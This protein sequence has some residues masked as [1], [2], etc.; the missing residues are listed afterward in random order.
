MKKSISSLGIA[1]ALVGI[2]GAQNTYVEA[3]RAEI[4][5]VKLNQLVYLT[6]Q[7]ASV[8]VKFFSAAQVGKAFGAVVF[9]SQTTGDVEVIGL[10]ST[11][12]P[13]VFVGSS[14]LTLS[15]QGTPANHG[16]GK[17]DLIP[18]EMFSAMVSYQLVGSSQH[19]GS[20]ALAADW[21]LMSDP[22]ASG[23]EVAV[24]V[25]AVLTPDE[26]NLPTGSRP[27][28]T[29][30]Q[31]GK[32]GPV[33][34]ASNELLFLPES[35]KEFQDFVARTGAVVLGYQGSTE[36]NPQQLPKA[37]DA[38]LRMQV[39]GD[40][41]KI[42]QLPALRRLFDS[43]EKLSVSNEA[44]LA[45]V[46]TAT[47]LWCE[48][49]AVGLNPR[50]QLH[51]QLYSPEGDWEILDDADMVIGRERIDAYGN[52]GDRNPT[53][54]NDGVY[55]IREM[56]AKISMFD[57]D[58]NPVPVGIIDSGFAPNPDFKTSHP[59]YAERNL[60]NNTSGIG[61]AQTQQEVGNSGFGEK[62]W[63]GNG[64]TTVISGVGGN[65]YGHRGIG[66]QTAV[67]K[68]YHMGLA[69]FAMGFGTA[70]DFA[71]NDGCSVIN[72]SAGYPCRVLSILGNDNICSPGDRALF[73][74]KLGLAVRGAAAAA[75][76][77]SGLLDAFLPG[78]GAAVCTSAIVA[79]ETAAAAFFATTFLGE[80]RGP[81]ETAVARATALGVPI[82]A[83]AGNDLG[84][85]D[86][87]PE[88]LASLVDLENTNLDDWQ[89]IPAVIP[90]VIAVGASSFTNNNEIP[91]FGY[92]HRANVQ[93]WGDSVD[94]W[95]PERSWY[96]APENGD[97]D[98]STVPVTSHVRRQFGGTSNSAPYVTGVIAN[99]LAIDTS[100]DRRFAPVTERPNLV[101]R[102]R[103]LLI[104][105]AYLAGSPELPDSA[106][107]VVTFMKN[108]E[109]VLVEVDEPAELLLQMARRRN[110]INPLGAVNQALANVGL[111]D[112]AALGYDMDL[113]DVDDF[114]D[115]GPPS[116]VREPVLL[117]PLSAVDEINERDREFWFIRIPS[118]GS[119]YRHD[120]QITIPLRENRTKLLV[121]GLPGSLVSSTASEQTLAW[122]TPPQWASGGARY[123][124]LSISGDGNKA[125]MLYKLMIARSTLPPPS[126]DSYDLG[127][128]SNDNLDEAPILSNWEAVAARGSL[129]QSAFEIC[130]EDLTFHTPADVDVFQIDFPNPPL[131]V[132][133]TC[134]ALNPWVS[135]RIEPPSGVM[136]LEV[137]SRAGGSDTLLARAG[138]SD[139]VRLDCRDY[140]GRMPLYVKVSSRSQAAIANYDLKVRWSEPSED[141]NNTLNNI[142]EAWAARDAPP[143]F[144]EFFQPEIPW[145]FNS[146]GPFPPEVVNPNP[147]YAN[148]QELG[149][150]GE[151]LASKLFF[152]EVPQDASNI[153]FVSLIPTS[154]SLRMEIVDPSG[155]VYAATGTPDLGY[156]IDQPEIFG[157]TRVLRADINGYNAGVYLLRL[158]GHSPGDRISLYLSQDLVSPGSVSIETLEGQGQ[159]LPIQLPPL[160]GFDDLRSAIFS[161]TAS[162]PEFTPG[163]LCLEAARE[164]EFFADGNTGYQMEAKGSDGIWEPIGTLIAFDQPQLFSQT[165]HIPPTGD[166]EIRIAKLG[167]GGTFPPSA[168]RP[169]RVVRYQSELGVPFS[170]K[171]SVDLET[172]TSIASG[173]VGDGT[174]QELFFNEVDLPG[175]EY[176]FTIRNP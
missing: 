56:W 74:A 90:E 161:S 120:V 84:G 72:I 156:Q 143:F 53:N 153:S 168:I 92:N 151:F 17:L 105:S 97:A 27:F 107:D 83:S 58:E 5:E 167:D 28:G 126:A 113:G 132:P 40:P 31:E 154:Q 44:T 170:L 112:F 39:T 102:I 149:L 171:G 71:V 76:A 139:V 15:N 32:P 79:A 136:R 96:W 26:L 55:G 114:V 155:I 119:L 66:G 22:N 141:L 142:R 30:Y 93:F 123:F 51:T 16:D 95:A 41:A 1:F 116:E 131:D 117:T 57:F 80:L 140:L 47:E 67:P 122:E 103:D 52:I 165:F 48:G 145:L 87:V 63:H 12:D 6:G 82:V 29:L 81:I 14:N 54:I 13:L 174:V 69:S 75:C 33:Q 19:N 35:E 49:F 129:E 169:A 2:S 173:L 160:E 59:L 135:F 121:N 134:S 4:P 86:S 148:S 88:P 61:T 3:A 9:S 78:L 108:E 60:S 115:L 18:G 64:T 89:I 128:A 127:S 101:G 45:L 125:D 73:M 21:G 65:Y 7:S 23:G 10:N 68:L 50:L 43:N 146:P 99:V 8:E 36:P 70:I 176:F 85:G 62:S 157:D 133:S 111:E 152:F 159:G 147:A 46:A 175:P 163:Q 77:A 20:R 110:M 166:P 91:N 94:I 109:D 37:G 38:W 144:E 104:N 172:F 24:N 137:F 162:F 11:S 98:P 124:P 42:A 25:G 150:N 100:L 138:G 118:T 106:D 130:V 34:V 164:V 158:S